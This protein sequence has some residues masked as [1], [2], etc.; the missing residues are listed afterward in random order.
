VEYYYKYIVKSS[1]N[2]GIIPFCWDTPGGI[3]NRSTGDIIN[4]DIVDAIIQGVRDTVSTGITSVNSALELY[5][6]PFSST[7][8][9]KAGNTDEILRISIFDMLGRQIETIEHS[10]I[11]SS[12]TIG[13]S[14]KS[15]IYIVQVYGLSWAKSFKVI[16]V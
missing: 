10:A 9:L 5:P 1:V 13:S 14:L 6:N 16:K 11:K 12:L 7:F 15:N 3:F 2:K 4:R 8:N